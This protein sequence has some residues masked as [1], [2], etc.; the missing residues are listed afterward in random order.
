M[1]SQ[2]ES[3]KEEKKVRAQYLAHELYTRTHISIVVCT[4]QKPIYDISNNV[5]KKRGLTKKNKKNDF[6][7]KNPS[8]IDLCETSFVQWNQ[9]SETMTTV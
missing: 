4:L 7:L 2:C 6:F 9:Q 1:S 3:L 8:F 5:P